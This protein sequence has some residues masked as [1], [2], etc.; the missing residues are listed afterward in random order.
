[1]VAKHIPDSVNI[2]LNHLQ[3]R[4]DEVPR[5]LRVTV[6]YAG[7][8]RSSIA[9]SILHQYGITNLMEIAGGV[10]PWDAASVPV[11]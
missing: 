7:G 6:H 10:A 3:Q 5:D 1:M 8:Y 9:V 2:P 4:I 11:D